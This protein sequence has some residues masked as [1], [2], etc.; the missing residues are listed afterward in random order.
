MSNDRTSAND[1]LELMLKLG[2]SVK[3]RGF[4]I[5]ALFGDGR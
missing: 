2:V 5:S 3:L 4:L 1:D